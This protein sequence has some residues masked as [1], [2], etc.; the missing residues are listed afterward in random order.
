VPQDRRRGDNPTHAGPQGQAPEASLLG[1]RDASADSAAVRRRPAGEPP[2]PAAPDFRVPKGTL[3][4]VYLLTDVD[5]GNAAATIQFGA[6]KSLYFNHREQIPFGTR[7]LGR[8]SGQVVRDRVTLTADTILYPDGLELPVDASAV[9]ADEAGASIYP[10]IAAYYFPPPAWAQAA[11]YISEFV[12]GYLGLLES[13]GQ[14]QL[15]VTAA[16]LG[17]QPTGAADPRVPLYQSSAQAIEGFTES[18]LKEIEQRY[19]SHYLVPAGTAFW[20]ELTSDLDLS[21]VH[22]PAAPPLPD[23][24]MRGHAPSLVSAQTHESPAN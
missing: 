7:F 14:P 4:S 1:Y 24:P 19:A 16:G 11:P 23:P 5:T 21:A 18:R 6:A 15:T 13:R 3:I 9:E 8:F 22:A 17:I 10:G 2:V 20:L 12:T